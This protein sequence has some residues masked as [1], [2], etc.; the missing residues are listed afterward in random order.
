MEFIS[1]PMGLLESMTREAKPIQIMELA[2]T[3]T[4]KRFYEPGGGLFGEKLGIREEIHSKELVVQ[5]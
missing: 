5:Q 1:G 2:P 3:M 4:M